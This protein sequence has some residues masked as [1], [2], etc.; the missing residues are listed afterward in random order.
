MTERGCDKVMTCKTDGSKS[1][2][3][4]ADDYD[5]T[6]KVSPNDPKDACGTSRQGGSVCEQICCDEQHSHCSSTNSHLRGYFQCMSERGCY[7]DGQKR[8]H[9]LKHTYSNAKPK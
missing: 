3:Y 4:S 9:G 1:G 2:Y 5:F 8:V 6:Y 7:T